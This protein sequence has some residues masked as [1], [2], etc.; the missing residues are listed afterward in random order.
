[1]FSEEQLCISPV[2]H[3]TPPLITKRHADVRAGRQRDVEPRESRAGGG[4]LA[5]DPDAEPSAAVLQVPGS[6]TIKGDRE[7]STVVR[8][9]VER[10]IGDRTVSQR[11][12]HEQIAKRRSEAY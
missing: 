4:Q 2:V 6:G 3:D 9:V 10:K 12:D 8:H 11:L 5:V 7:V 1:M